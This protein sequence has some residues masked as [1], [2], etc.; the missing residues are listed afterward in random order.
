MA[1]P[2]TVVADN[3]LT[4]IAN[5]FGIADWRTIYFDPSNAA[6]RAKRPDP[7]HIF[8]GDIIMIP[9]ITT[10]LAATSSTPPAPLTITPIPPPPLFRRWSGIVK[11]TPIATAGPI[12]FAGGDHL[13][14][15]LTNSLLDKTD[16]QVSAVAIG[17]SARLKAS[18]LV[19]LTGFASGVA[20]FVALDPPPV[21]WEVT[22][23]IIGT[24]ATVIGTTPWTR[25]LTFAASGEVKWEL[26]L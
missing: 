10:P 6:F 22:V 11:G 17:A 7:N 26:W 25:P 14:V 12:V 3:F 20:A 2:Y 24:P 5:K 1:V 13:E 18:K 15:R 9:L 21:R 19:S 4:K 16:L 8:A 23:M